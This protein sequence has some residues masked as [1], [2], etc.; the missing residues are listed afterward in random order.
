MKSKDKRYRLSVFRSNRFISAQIID[1]EKGA[2]IL[3]VSGKNL[4]EKVKGSK[5]EKAEILGE[6]LAK[7]ALKKGVKKIKFDRGN[8]RYHGRVKA[9]AE[10]A[11]K[12]GLE[13]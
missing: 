6:F 13:F 8:S 1:D 4:G 12:G 11:R 7:E 3:G 5:S 2:T 10:G 9:L